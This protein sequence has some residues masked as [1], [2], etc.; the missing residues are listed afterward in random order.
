MAKIKGVRCIERNGKTYW[1]AALGGKVPQY[2]GKGEKGRKL[3]EAARS[4]YMAKKYEAREVAAG[5]NTQRVEFKNV[6]DMLNWYMELPRVQKRKSYNR[7][8]A[9]C[10]HLLEYFGSKPVYGIESDDI[11]RYRESGSYGDM[12]S[13]DGVFPAIADRRAGMDE[14]FRTTGQYL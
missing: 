6:Q 9:T 13:I 7:K 8:V 14:Y 10:V 12:D 11:E 5:I 2:C 4:K 1:Y 3:A